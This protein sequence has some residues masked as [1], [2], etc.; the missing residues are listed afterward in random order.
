MPTKK[1]LIIK[2]FE[3]LDA[4]MLEVLLNDGQAYQDV[5]KDIFVEELK[6]YFSEI[7]NYEDT[8]FDFK[9]YKGVCNKCNKGKTGFSFINS[10][11]ECMMSMVFEE[12]EEDF[13]D[14]YTCGSFHTFEK[15]IENEWTGISFYEEDNINYLPSS[16]N[17]HDE[18]WANR[19]VKEI[20]DEMVNE[21]ILSA[22]FCI[23][24][25]HENEKLDDLSEIFEGKFYR[26]KKRIKSYINKLRFIVSMFENEK[27]AKKYW[28][29]FI[30]FPEITEEYIKNWLKRCDHDLHNHIYGFPYES[31]FKL[32]YFEEQNIKFDLESV[33]YIQNLSEILNKYFDWIPIPNP[34]TEKEQENITF[35]KDSDYPF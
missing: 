17:I 12:N 32:K 7:K 4:D 35:E 31:D 21:G 9:A 13:T 20:E 3:N 10:S 16:K 24:W 14:I 25:F 11:D 22:Q 28:Q 6:R 23:N 15:E 27:L 18:K 33:Y 26:Y 29:E 8:P 19:A 5:P 2:A 34:I 1:Q 30:G